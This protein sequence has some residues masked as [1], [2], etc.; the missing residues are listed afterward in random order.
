M[1]VD[2]MAV[3]LMAD[4]NRTGSVPGPCNIFMALQQISLSV[5]K[6]KNSRNSLETMSSLYGYTA[7]TTAFG[8]NSELRLGD[9]D[10]V[11]FSIM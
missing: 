1:V 2:A 3:F 9:G 11:H 5:E 7:E 8:F 6:P 10:D 4:A